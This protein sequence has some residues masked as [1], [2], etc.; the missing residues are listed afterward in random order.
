MS[1]EHENKSTCDEE[2][3]T[4][5]RTNSKEAPRDGISVLNRPRIALNAHGKERYEDESTV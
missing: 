3:T 5:H 2:P 1:I 4:A